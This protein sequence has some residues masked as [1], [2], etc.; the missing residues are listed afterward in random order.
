M[1]IKREIIVFKR[2]KSMSSAWLGV[3]IHSTGINLVELSNLAGQLFLQ[4]CVQGTLP[5]GAVVSGVIKHADAVSHCLRSL[6]QN[7]L[8]LS[9][10]A[11]LAIPDALSMRKIIQV[12]VDLQPDEIEQMV[13]QDTDGHI[14]Y[15]L[16]EISLDFQILGR[17]THHSNMLDVLLVA[18][19]TETIQQRVDVITSSELSPYVVEIESDALA[20]ARSQQYLFREMGYQFELAYGLALRG[21][22]SLWI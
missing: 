6:L 2:D 15:P 14:P 10:Q 12:S 7:N 4:A 8:F 18:V 5:E 13:M 1:Q 21:N 16:H 20:R 9:K 17:S 11:I 22:Q 19:Q 3:D